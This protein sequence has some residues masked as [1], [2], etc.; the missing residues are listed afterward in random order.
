MTLTIIFHFRKQINLL[1]TNQLV[2][3]FMSNNIFSFERSKNDIFLMYFDNS[4][5]CISE[6]TIFFYNEV[7]VSSV[8]ATLRVY[9]RSLEG[10]L[11]NRELTVCFKWFKAH[12]VF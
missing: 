6:V 10:G 2:L 9:E 11:Q 7:L 3:L 4:N 1:V 5:V 12:R 8:D